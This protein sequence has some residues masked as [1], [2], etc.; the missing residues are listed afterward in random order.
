M[1]K[2][3]GVDLRGSPSR[4]SGIAVLS[5]KVDF[6]GLAYSDS[7]IIDTITRFKPV[8]AVIDSP[9]SHSKS[10]RN[11]DRAMI[12]LGFRV[13]PPGWRGMRMLVERSLRLASILS[14][15]GIRV[16]ETH[17]KSALKSSRCSSIDEL[18]RRMGYT[19]PGGLSEDEKDAL[20]SALVG[21]AYLRGLVVEITDTDGSI[22]LLPPIC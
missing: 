14:N 10:F 17:P 6:I 4:P 13:L 1:V 21:V 22:F 16:L 2:T 5:D 19:V 8:L 11:V 9:L 20:V 18:A 15:Y 12:R 3:C 7:E